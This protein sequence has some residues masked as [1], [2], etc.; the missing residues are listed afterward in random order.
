MAEFVG[1]FPST[2][3]LDE[4][5]NVVTEAEAYVYDVEDATLSSPLPVTDLQGVPFTG[6]KLVAANGILPQFRAPT[7]ITQVYVRSGERVTQLTDLSVYADTSREA[8]DRAGQA[9]TDAASAKTTAETASAEALA[10]AELLQEIALQQGAPLVEDPAE[11]G[12][13]T[14]LNPRA[15]REDPD[16]PGT[17]L[18]GVTA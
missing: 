9:A 7:G 2:L 4:R 6:G 3:A 14:I 1:A 12:T 8:A 5:N 17:F 11:P 18:M 15:I 13:F 16:E 10:A